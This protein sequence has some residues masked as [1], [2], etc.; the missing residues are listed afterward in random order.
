MHD[1]SYCYVH[2]TLYLTYFLGKEI[3][4]DY[5]QSEMSDAQMELKHQLELLRDIWAIFENEKEA[6]KALEETERERKGG[7]RR[8]NVR[9]TTRILIR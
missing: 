9:R 4:L 6:A 7:R 5:H 1:N 8:G 3:A 2:E